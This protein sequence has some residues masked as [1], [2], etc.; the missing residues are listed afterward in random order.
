[1][2]KLGFPRTL[3]GSG[4]QKV[5][6]PPAGPCAITHPFHTLPNG[7][8]TANVSGWINVTR[9]ARRVAARTRRVGCRDILLHLVTL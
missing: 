5:R 1:V 9:D 4:E 7:L 3:P 6:R 2:L 8:T